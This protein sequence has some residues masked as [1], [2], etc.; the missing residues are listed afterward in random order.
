MLKLPQE[1]ENYNRTLDSGPQVEQGMPERRWSS[2][3]LWQRRWEACEPRIEPPPPAPQKIL[4]SPLLQIPHWVINPADITLSHTT[5]HSQTHWTCGAP[6]RLVPRRF[7]FLAASKMLWKKSWPSVGSLSTA[8]W[9]HEYDATFRMGFPNC[10]SASGGRLTGPVYVLRVGGGARRFLPRHR[11]FAAAHST[12]T[13]RAM[14]LC[15]DSAHDHWIS[16][17]QKESKPHITGHKYQSMHKPVTQD[18]I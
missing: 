7:A 4:P 5:R 6:K 8:S 16:R 18:H 14:G 9:I 3:G 12:L 10:S 17:V 15:T 13:T 11:V 1:A 2:T